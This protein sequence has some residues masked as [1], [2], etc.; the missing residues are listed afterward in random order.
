LKARAFAEMYRVLKPGGRLLIV[1][2]EPPRNPFTRFYLSI[3]LGNGMMQID[4]ST[5]PPLL[6]KVGFKQVNLGRTGSRMGTAVS[7]I[8]PAR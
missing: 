1:D 2:F 6:D 8:K 7:A 5:L 4:N 3:F